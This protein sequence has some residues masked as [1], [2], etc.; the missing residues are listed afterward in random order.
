M[1]DDC[2]FTTGH[3]EGVASLLQVSEYD[4]NFLFFIFGH[5]R[6]VRIVHRRCAQE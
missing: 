4:N 6:D 5:E 3:D 1:G 2:G